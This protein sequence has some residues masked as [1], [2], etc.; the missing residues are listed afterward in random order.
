[1]AELNIIRNADNCI[2]CNECFVVCPQ[3]SPDNPDSVISLAAKEGDPP[4]IKHIQNCIQCMLCLD[5][6][7]CDA[8]SFENAHEVEIIIRDERLEKAVKRMI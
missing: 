3:S 4:E 5:H 2:G 6:C 7:R 8:I 1:M